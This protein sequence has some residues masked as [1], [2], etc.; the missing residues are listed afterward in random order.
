MFPRDDRKTP[1]TSRSS[2]VSTQNSHVEKPPDSS[3][4]QAGQVRRVSASRSLQTGQL[5][6]GLRVGVRATLFDRHADAAE[7]AVDVERAGAVPELGLVAAG[8]RDPLAFNGDDAQP[9]RPAEVV[10]PAITRLNLRS[11]STVDAIDPDVSGL[12]AGHQRHR[13]IH[14]DPQRF[15]ERIGTTRA[16]KEL[17]AIVAESGLLD[18]HRVAVL[19]DAVRAVCNRI[20]H[21]CVA[22]HL[23]VAETG[24]DFHLLRAG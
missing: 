6:G 10:D 14:P 19:T 18:Q 17:E 7:G 24:H 3:V 15:A 21:A 11:E 23:G 16:T 22:Y 1:S 5:S 8:V 4:S 20:A 2:F 9:N 12:H 13:G